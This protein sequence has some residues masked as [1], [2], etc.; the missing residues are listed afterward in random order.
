MIGMT[1][2]SDRTGCLM[3]VVFVLTCYTTPWMCT[4][5][6]NVISSAGFV[7]ISATIYLQHAAQLVNYLMSRHLFNYELK[8]NS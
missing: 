2:G 4:P 1:K 6:V 5:Q 8:Q 3:L 7:I